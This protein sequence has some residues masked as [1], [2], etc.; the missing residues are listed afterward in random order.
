MLVKRML[1]IS[2]EDLAPDGSELFRQMPASCMVMDT[3]MRIV[4]ASDLYL[5]TVRRDL[6][7]IRGRYVFDAFPEQPG[8]VEMFRDAFARALRGEANTIDEALYSVPVTNGDGTPTGEMREIF[9]TCHHA[10]LVWADGTIRHIVQHATDVTDKVRAERLK[11]AIA[12]ELQ[13]RTSNV[14]TLVSAIAKRTAASAD[15]LADFLP[16]FEARMLALSRTHSYLTGD[17]WDGMTIEQ[18]VAREVEGFGETSNR[19]TL[20]GEEI[21][22]NFAEAQI[23][24]IAVHELA[25]NSVKYGALNGVAGNIHVE[26]GPADKG[27]Y[28]FEWREQGISFD[29]KPTRK[30]FGSFILDTVAPEQLRASA[31]REFTPGAFLYSLAV[32]DRP[33]TA[34]EHPGRGL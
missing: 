9:W 5:Q 15:D 28:R 21:V 30:G 10:P 20:L 1:Q 14:L 8:S 7:D 25:T 32:A 17:N 12:G 23:M 19:I 11:D 33:S 34:R 24:T 27:G 2:S 18:I 22:L 29:P 4:T 3:E 16:R 6:D 13:H 26:W 31:R